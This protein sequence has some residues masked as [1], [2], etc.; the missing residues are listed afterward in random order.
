MLR[1]Y[2]FK[3]KARMIINLCFYILFLIMVIYAAVNNKDD[4]ASILFVVLG[5]DYLITDIEADK[6]V[7]DHIARHNKISVIKEE[8]LQR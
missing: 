7:I 6:D 1:H 4:I 5:I 3:Q 8:P 2:S